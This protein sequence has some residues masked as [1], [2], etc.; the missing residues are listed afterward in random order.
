MCSLQKINAKVMQAVVTGIQDLEKLESQGETEQHL[1]HFQHKLGAILQKREILQA[2]SCHMRQKTTNVLGLA[3][4]QVENTNSVPATPKNWVHIGG[5]TSPALQVCFDQM[6]FFRRFVINAG[7]FPE[8]Q[9]PG[10]SNHMTNLTASLHILSHLERG[11]Q[12]LCRLF[13][14]A[15]TYW[16]VCSHLSFVHL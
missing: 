10:S 9:S 1:Y 7:P 14:Y 11:K 15:G 6:S 13:F 3:F 4:L 12:T 2:V 5:G 16:W 8:S